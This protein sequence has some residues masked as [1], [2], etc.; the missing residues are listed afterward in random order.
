MSKPEGWREEDGAL[1][2]EFEL[3]SFPAAIAFV[4]RVAELAERENHHPDIDIRYRKVLV[5]WTT[6]SAGGITDRDR[7]MA[8]RTSACE[9]T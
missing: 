5:R 7:D 9:P 1:V 4:S 8:A 6:H 3:E 2:R